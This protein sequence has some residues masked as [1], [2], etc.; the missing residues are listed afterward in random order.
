MVDKYKGKQ[1]GNF[2]DVAFWEFVQYIGG[3]DI[4]LKGLS[5]IWINQRVGSSHIHERLDQAFNYHQWHIL[6][7]QVGLSH[8]IV[9]QSNHCL[10]LLNI[11]SDGDNNPRP[12]TFFATWFS[13]ETSKTIISKAWKHQNEDS[14]AFQLIQKGKITKVHL[15]RWNTS[16]YGFTHTRI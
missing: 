4:P 16:H 12:F 6:Y 13:D 15:K 5:F 2:H 3:L 9:T 11:I 8:L 14:H 10:I 1:V 7:P